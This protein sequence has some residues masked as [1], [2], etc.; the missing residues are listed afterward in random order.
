MVSQ[1]TIT[2]NQKPGGGKALQKKRAWFKSYRALDKG[3]MVADAKRIKTVYIDAKHVAEHA[4]WL[5]KSAAEKEEFATVSPDG[6][7]KE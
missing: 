5:G 4:V 1:R 2:G 6:D 7:K 3:N